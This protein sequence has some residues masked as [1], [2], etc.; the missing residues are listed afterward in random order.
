L[1]TA[2]KDA[3]KGH[4]G[5]AVGV[6]ADRTGKDL[7]GIGAF[8]A[9]IAPPLSATANKTTTNYI[10]PTFHIHDAHDAKKTGQ[11]VQE[12]ISNLLNGTARQIGVGSK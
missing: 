12:H 3:S 10:N 9:H 1:T 5:A 6:L 11:V 4:Y 2:A 7:T 8:L